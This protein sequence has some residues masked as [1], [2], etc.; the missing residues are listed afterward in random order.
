MSGK[1]RTWLW[2]ILACIG[3]CVIAMFVIAGAGMYF[4]MKHINVAKSTSADALR[5][6]DEARKVFKDQQPLFIIDSR[7]QPKL[8]RPL[9]DIPSSTTKAEN[10]WILAW[11]PDEEKLVKLSLPMW[12]VR[13]G[14]QKMDVTSGGGFDLERLNIDWRE[15]DRI[16]PV[17]VFDLKS[18]RGER[19]L[20]WT[21]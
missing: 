5:S 2:I 17:L 9:T 1:K 8:A 18:S 16:G 11:D 7:E 20:I 13:M 6:F 12:L 19:V 3:V 14:K 4:V 10:L 21:R 15:L